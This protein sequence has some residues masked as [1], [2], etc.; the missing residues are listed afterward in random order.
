MS[1]DEIR[2]KALKLS[3]EERSELVAALLDSLSGADPND[4]DADS[5]SEARHRGEAIVS[6][7]VKG[8]SEEECLGDIRA[9]RQQP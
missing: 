9:S 2:E 5:L 1:I 4:F 3:E 7:E 6:G 8:L